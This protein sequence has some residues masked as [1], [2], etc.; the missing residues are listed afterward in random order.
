MKGIVLLSLAGLTLITATAFAQAAEESPCRRDCTPQCLPGPCLRLPLESAGATYFSRTCGVCLPGG[1]GAVVYHRPCQWRLPGGGAPELFHRP[2][3]LCLP[4]GAGAAFFHRPCQLCLPAG[5]GAVL[6]SR[7]LSLPRP[8]GLGQAF[9]P[10]ASPTACPPT[11]DAAPSTSTPPREAGRSQR[12]C[13]A[14]RNG[15][16]YDSTRPP[17][18]FPRRT[19]NAR[20]GKA[21][22][23]STTLAGSGLCRTWMSTLTAPKSL[24]FGSVP[25][26]AKALTDRV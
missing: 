6:F 3:Q 26:L 4:N 25:V 15:P 9:Q 17:L 19:A 12:R 2:C 8:C 14:V 10:W 18:F 13:C 21:K 24:A 1:E 20:A 23:A 22:I 16:A 5:D 7:P 11:P